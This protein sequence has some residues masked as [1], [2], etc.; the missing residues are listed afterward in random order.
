MRHVK[1]LF[2]IVMSLMLILTNTVFVNASEEIDTSEAFELAEE[3]LTEY[4]YAIDMF[5]DYDFAKYTT[6]ENF[7]T[8]VEKRVNSEVYAS[9]VYTNIVRYDYSVEFDDLSFENLG[10]CV[11]LYIGSTVKFRYAPEEEYSI[12]GEG[13]YFLVNNGSNGLEIRD[14]YVPLDPYDEAIRGDILISDP[15]YWDN[16]T[17][18]VSIYRSQ[19]LR[20]E[21]IL[22]NYE[23]SVQSKNAVISNSQYDNVNDELNPTAVSATLYAVNHTNVAKWAKDNW[24]ADPPTSGD[25]SQVSTYKDFHTISSSAWDCT[26]FASHAIL[27]GGAVI[28]DTGNSG[29]SSTG[30]YYRDTYNRSSSWS[31]KRAVQLPNQ[32]HHK[33]TCWKRG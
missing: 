3:F 21:S 24:D 8:Y 27:Y 30:W 17:E 25:S 23:L 4:Y 15:Y 26:N 6:S 1:R 5:Q 19:Q 22:A 20:D 28:Y 10:N 14:W 11:R 13:I 12:Y 16:S 18:R 2:T 9:E 33:R 7:L 29:I 32:K 31:G